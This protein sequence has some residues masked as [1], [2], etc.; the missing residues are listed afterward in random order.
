MQLSTYLHLAPK[1]GMYILMASAGTS[2]LPSDD[3]TGDNTLNVL[4]SVVCLC[5]PK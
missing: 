5:D 4:P 3:A 2:L 1:L